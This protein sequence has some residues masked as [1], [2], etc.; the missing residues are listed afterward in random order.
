[1]VWAIVIEAWTCVLLCTLLF[2]P[3]WLSCSLLIIVGF[4]VEYSNN[5]GWSGVQ[6]AGARRC[7]IHKCADLI[8][9]SKKR[10]GLPYT[11]EHVCHCSPNSAHLKVTPVTLE[12]FAEYS[13]KLRL[14]GC[15]K[16]YVFCP[17]CFIWAELAVIVVELVDCHPLFDL[18][19]APIKYVESISAEMVTS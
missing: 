10:S 14:F 4:S 17:Y 5:A 19:T 18:E 1:M 8:Q 13:C 11:D 16:C 7:S 3:R 6:T 9:C 15:M 12:P 2:W